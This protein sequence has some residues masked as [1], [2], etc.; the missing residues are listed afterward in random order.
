MNRASKKRLYQYTIAIVHFVDTLPH[1]I[2]GRRIADQLFRSGTSV[3]AN[4]VEAQAASTRKEY[5]NFF[6][7]ALKSANETL[8]WLCLLRDSKKVNS[9]H[10][11]MLIKETDEICKMLGRTVV[12][13]RKEK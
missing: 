8:F 5:T 13:L 7:I 12:N 10:L 6:A 4:A 2:A 1:D 11:H 3:M 9:D